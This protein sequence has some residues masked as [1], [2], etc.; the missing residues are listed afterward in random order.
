MTCKKCGGEL[1]SFEG[2]KAGY[3]SSCTSKMDADS[4]EAKEVRRK[5]GYE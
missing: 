3:C 4:P 5:L 1:A 2:K